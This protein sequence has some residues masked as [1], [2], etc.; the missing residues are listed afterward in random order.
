MTM[1]LVLVLVGMA[2][3]VLSSLIKKEHWKSETKQTVAVVLSLI[4]GVVSTQLNS[5]N[6]DPATVLAQGAAAL[7]ISQ[8]VFTY[9]LKTTGLEK[10]LAEI[11]SK[12]S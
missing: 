10:I 12:K 8:A 7:G 6:V 9:I 2:V 11:G 4:G 5:A 1:N 3:S